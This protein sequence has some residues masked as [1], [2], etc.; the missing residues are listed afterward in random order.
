MAACVDKSNGR[1]LVNEHFQVTNCHPITSV[2]QPD[3]VVHKNIFSFGDV[4]QTKLN[5]EKNLVSILQFKHIISHNIQQVAME[6]V[7][8]MA[9]PDEA[10]T[11]QM[12]PMGNSNGFFAFNSMVTDKPDAPQAHR[13]ASLRYKGMFTGDQK[14]IDAQMNMGKDFA[15]F[16]GMASGCC[17]CLPMHIKK[18]RAGNAARA[19]SDKDAFNKAYQ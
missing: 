14:S 9:L 3:P 10:H 19:A 6:T 15:G 18:A 1:I 4:C 8:L 5:E 12:M 16:M 13:D 17:Y 2:N 7:N 11:I